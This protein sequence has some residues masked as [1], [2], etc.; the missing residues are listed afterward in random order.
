MTR[1]GGVLALLAAT[2]SASALADNDRSCL[3]KKCSVGDKVVTVATKQDPFFACPNRELASYTNTVVG[4]IQ[5]QVALSGT[6]PNISDKT[7]EPEYRDQGGQPNRTRL[8]LDGLRRGAG[9]STFDQAVARCASGPNRSTVTILNVDT[10]SNVVWVNDERK[11]V[12]FWM[13]MGNLDKR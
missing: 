9:V 12:S 11:K 8:M 5:M 13:P 10:D 4:L 6:F 2:V 1:F 3:V 7:G